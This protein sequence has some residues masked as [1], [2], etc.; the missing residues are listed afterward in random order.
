MQ[1][2]EALVPR[3]EEFIGFVE[4]MGESDEAGD[5]AFAT[6]NCGSNFLRAD[7]AESFTNVAAVMENMPVAEGS[8]LRVPKVGEDEWFSVFVFL[9][10][11]RIRYCVC[12]SAHGFL[13]LAF[14]IL[15]VFVVRKYESAT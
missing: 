15:N 13:S 12:Q 4:T 10:L 6:L 14:R 3:M 5:G 2:V 7:T 9:F 8:Y 11:L 1:Q